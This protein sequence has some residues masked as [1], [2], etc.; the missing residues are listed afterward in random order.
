MYFC[1]A[2]LFPSTTENCSTC[3]INTFEKQKEII[4]CSVMLKNGAPGMAVMDNDDFKA[5]T[6]TSIYLTDN[7]LLKQ[8]ILKYIFIRK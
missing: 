6:L 2:F 1:L 5:D 4:H 3:I 7:V 8:T